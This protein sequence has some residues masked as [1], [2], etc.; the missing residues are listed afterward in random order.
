MTLALL[1]LA[2]SLFVAIHPLRLALVTDNEITIDHNVALKWKDIEVAKEFKASYI[3]TQQA[4]ALHVRKGVTHKLTFMQKICKNN[5]FTPF[6]IPLYA[7][8]PKD[9]QKIRKIIKDLREYN[10]F[11]Y[12]IK[13]LLSLFKYNMIREDEFLI[14]AKKNNK[15]INIENINDINEIISNLKAFLNSDYHNYINMNEFFELKKDINLIGFF[16]FLKSTYPSLS[17]PV[18]FMSCQKSQGFTVR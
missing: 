3:Y 13:K 17:K 11:Y 5:V 1:A 2:G 14:K 9:A 10:C 4:I 8:T 18:V 15:Y 12:Y 7:M 6:S 16:P